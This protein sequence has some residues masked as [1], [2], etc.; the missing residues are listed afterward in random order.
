MVS[1]PE[2]ESGTHA[3]KARVSPSTPHRENHQR[4]DNQIR[5]D[6]IYLEGRYVSRYTISAL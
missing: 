6:D 5:T 2:L 1:V 4:A 3:P